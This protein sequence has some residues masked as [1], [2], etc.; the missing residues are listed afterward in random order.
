MLVGAIRQQGAS[1][2]PGVCHGAL[3]LSG[4][5]ELGFIRDPTIAPLLFCDVDRFISRSQQRRGRRKPGAF[6]LNC[7]PGGNGDLDAC[8]LAYVVACGPEGSH[9]SLGSDASTL[10]SSARQQDHELLAPVAS[11]EVGVSCARLE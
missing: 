10:F 1:A 7:K 8:P 9:N 6:T 5:L 11:H 4:A 2:L 3:R